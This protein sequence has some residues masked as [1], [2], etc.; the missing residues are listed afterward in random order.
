M[1]K[2]GNPANETNI[3][4]LFLKNKEPEHDLDPENKSMRD[5]AGMQPAH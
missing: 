4:N 3:L 5:E 1:P 2:H